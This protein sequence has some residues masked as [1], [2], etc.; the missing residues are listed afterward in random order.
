MTST[1]VEPKVIVMIDL[2]T[3][4]LGADSVI[5]EAAMVSVA[6]DDPTTYVRE[7]QT[8]LPIQPQ[9]DLIGARRKID[10]ETLG[11]WLEKPEESRLRLK[12]AIFGDYD[13]LAALVRSIERAFKEMIVGLK[14]DEYIVVCKGLNFDVP[15]LTSLFASF[16]IKAPWYYRGLHCL[17][18]TMRDAG[19]DQF[20]IP[21]IDG[22]I[23]HQALWDCKHQLN[24]WVASQKLL[25]TGRL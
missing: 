17:R 8:F 6:Y 1:I 15:L 12:E 24:L 20:S 7:F 2:E 16:G 3:L 9:L 23:A 4:G 11:Y 14:N 5:W 10:A 18:S 13:D 22:G 19:L 25:A 21:F